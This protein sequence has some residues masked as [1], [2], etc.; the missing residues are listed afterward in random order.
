MSEFYENYF[1]GNIIEETL[2]HEATHT[3]I[4]DIYPER[5]TNGEG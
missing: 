5:E 1:T 2:I 3:S 4:D